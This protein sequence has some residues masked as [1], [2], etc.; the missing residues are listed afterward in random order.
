MYTKSKPNP[1][2]MEAF[3]DG[4][5]TLSEQ[6][7]VQTFLDENPDDLALLEALKADH[8]LMQDALRARTEEAM[9]SIDWDQFST[10]VME[11]VA[12][13]E[14]PCP[15]Q[16]NLRN[17]EVEETS[18]GW[19]TRLRNWMQWVRLHPGLSLSCVAM[20]GVLMIVSFTFM[21]PGPNPDNTVLVEKISNI[22]TAQVAVMQSKNK[23]TGKNMTIIVV[24]EPI[25]D[26]NSVSPSNKRRPH[27]NKDGNATQ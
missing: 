1:E 2:K 3:L 22:K 11:Q 26:D 4:E 14:A 5:L 10:R 12:R 21:D 27:P 20:A 18:T 13:E 19:I 16:A 23:A 15:V 24:N 17:V 8:S 25:F 6:R 9:A 7:E